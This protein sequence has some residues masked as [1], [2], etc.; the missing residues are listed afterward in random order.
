MDGAGDSPA[1]AHGKVTITRGELEQRVRD[2]RIVDGHGDLHA[3]NI[4]VT[5]DGYEP[6]TAHPKTIEDVVI[7]PG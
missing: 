5:D 7:R 3:R 1:L 4:F 2:G 6:V